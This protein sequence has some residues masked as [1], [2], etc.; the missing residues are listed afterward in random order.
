MMGNNAF[1]ICRHGIYCYKQFRDV[2]FEIEEEIL[3]K[4]SD[5]TLSLINR[6]L[7]TSHSALQIKFAQPWIILNIG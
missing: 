4:I 7:K 1:Q 2:G 3:G 6:I 5:H